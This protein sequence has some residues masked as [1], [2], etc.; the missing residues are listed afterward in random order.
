MISDRWNPNGN[1]AS[2]TF[3]HEVISINALSTKD[4]KEIIR[5]SAT[6]NLSRR[7][8]LKLRQKGDVVLIAKEIS[9]EK[10]FVFTPGRTGRQGREFKRCR[11][12]LADGVGKL[13]KADSF[14]RWKQV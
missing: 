2:S 13:L 8:P 14:H 3:L 7:S 9:I 5:L 12:L 11:D 6:G 1:F 10:V 4:V